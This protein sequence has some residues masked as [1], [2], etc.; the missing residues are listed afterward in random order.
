MAKVYVI[1]G[2]SLLFR[3][4]FATAYGPNA[5]VMRTKEG[6]PTNA[7]FAFGNM[8]NKIISSFKGGEHIIVGFDVGKKTFRNDEYEEYKANRKPTDADLVVQM[9]LA[10]ELLTSLGIFVYEQEGYEADDVCGT[11]AKVA[12]KAGHQVIVY[13]SDRDFL[14]LIDHNIAIHILKTGMSNIMVMDEV[15]MPQEFGISP[16][17][18]PDYKGLRGDASDNLPGIPGIGEKTAVKLL[19]QYGTFEKILEEAKNIDGK[20]G[21]NLVE[22]AKIGQLSKRLAT[23]KTD[24]ELPFTLA[25]TMYQGYV[26]DTINQFGQR[27]ELKQLLNRLPSK[28]KIE[29]ERDVKIEYQKISSFKNVELGSKIALFID[30]KEDNY[31]KAPIL[32]LALS[33]GVN[34]YYINLDDAVRDQDLKTMLEDEKI[35]KSCFD[36][37]ATTVALHRLGIALRGMSFDLLLAAYLLDSSLKNNVDSILN[38][39]GVDAHGKDDRELSLFDESNPLRTAKV[40][41]LT[42]K[43]QA[44]VIAELKKHEALKL[45]EEIEM[46]LALVLAKMEIEGFPL[47]AKAL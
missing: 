33:N 7:L 38:Y 37:K 26:F 2:N 34:H 20:I 14:Q 29:S 44:R 12:S 5:K 40:A 28:Y 46:P 42:L 43:L 27:Y 18:I 30:M 24:I 6:V 9:P 10:R 19:Q 3:A 23:I 36:I 13:T 1:D 11:I 35:S 47:D 41:Y 4:Y 15:T 39:F 32:G 45:Y 22:H 31:F 21:Q 17:Q 25:D 8:I 16:A